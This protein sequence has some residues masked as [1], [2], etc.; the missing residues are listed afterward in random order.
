MCLDSDPSAAEVMYSVATRRSM[1][2]RPPVYTRAILDFNFSAAPTGSEPC[3]VQLMIENTGSVGSDWLV[4]RND[5]V[6]IR[7]K[8]LDVEKMYFGVF[9]YNFNVSMSS[10]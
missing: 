9:H 4:T 2:R 5:I 6:L 3:N 10:E 8:T 7:M 1:N